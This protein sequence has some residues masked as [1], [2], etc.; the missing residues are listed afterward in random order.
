MKN[1]PITKKLVTKII[2]TVSCG[3]SN[4]LGKQ[5][6]G[7]MCVEAAICYAY[8]LPHGDNPPCVGSAVRAFKIALNDSNWSSSKA[9][10]KG[11]IDLSIAQLNSNVIDQVEFSTK[12]TMKVINTIIAK[13]AQDFDNELAKKLKLVS[14]PADAV[15]LCRQLT[16]YDANYAAA[17][18]A[19]YAA[20]YA[21]SAAEYAES[22]K[23]A[24][25]YAAEYAA[26]AAK[27]AAKYAEYAKSAAE[28]D[29]VLNQ[30][31][32]IGLDVLIE[33]KSPGVK[34]LYLLKQ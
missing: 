21:E 14:N 15:L 32:K 31:A 19:K 5:V 11:M 24:A 29:K 22:T 28:S 25:H 30:V 8:G 33:M 12:V 20:E 3:L 6:P 26:Y 16:T 17:Y 1:K 23:Y 34:Y 13:I 27:S 4:G 9:R 18:A 7:E 10:A 2:E